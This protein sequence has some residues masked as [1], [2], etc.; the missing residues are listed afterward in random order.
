MFISDLNECEKFVAGD[1]SVL[2]ELLHPDKANIDLRYSLAHAVVKPGLLTTLH[3]LAT[4]EVY[5]I[6]SGEG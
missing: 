3:S 2:K 6:L 4:S 5:Y 1:N